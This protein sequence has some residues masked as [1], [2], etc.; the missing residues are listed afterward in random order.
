MAQLLSLI[1]YGFSS[2][3]KELYTKRVKAAFSEAFGIPEADCVLYITNYTS[4]DSCANF[5]EKL[6][7]NITMP[8][9]KTDEQKNTFA[10]LYKEACDSTFG[11]RTLPA[12]AT[13]DEHEP[14]NEYVNGSL[15]SK[16]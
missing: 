5:M 2:R 13:I 4:E 6:H 3:E 16:A 8:A 10:K 9:G 14:T 11:D 7:C 12:F 15:L 1:P